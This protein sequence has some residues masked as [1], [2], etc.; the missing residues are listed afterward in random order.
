M[1]DNPDPLS[2]IIFT[3]PSTSDA[4]AVLDLMI[5]VDIAEYGEPDSELEDLLQE[6]GEIDLSKDAWLVPDQQDRAIGYGK[7]AAGD[8]EFQMDFYV[9]PRSNIDDLRT[10]IILRCE[11]RVQEL[12]ISAGHQSSVVLHTIAS[13]TNRADNA[14]LEKHGYKHGKYYLRMQ[15]TMDQ[16][17]GK[18]AWP[19]GVQ[20]RTI[21]QG[22]DD[23][24][25]FEFVNRNISHA[26]RTPGDFERWRSWMMRED[27]FIPELWFLLF[28][29][30]EIIG[31]ALCYDY[32][33]Y[34]WV[35][36]L[37][38]SPSWRRSGLGTALLQHSFYCFYSRGHRR[39]ALGV[40]A[41][42]L[43][44]LQFYEQVGMQRVRQYNEYV[45]Q[46]PTVS[47]ENNI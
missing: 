12:Q 43:D 23:L 30:Q 18:P 36:Q 6:W 3:R 41:K 31:A 7:V 37:A 4:T 20:L 11:K 8:T 5:A 27:H 16:Q 46:I 35:R 9:H 19:A 13:Q 44:A 1:L 10:E 14:A 25:V 21:I 39:V 32:E 33:E 24:P 28:A 15:H 22:E 38:V 2:N 45:K 42:N 40:E 34:G 26:G 29:D 17:P 47:T